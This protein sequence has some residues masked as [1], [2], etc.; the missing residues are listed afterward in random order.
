MTSLPGHLGQPRLTSYWP[1]A[2]LRVRI[3]VG[4]PA[5]SAGAL[6]LR[7]PDDDDLSALAA[8]AEAGVHDPDL[9]P[10]AVPW[11][12]AEPAERARS[13]MQFHWRCLGS[14]S[15]D[16]WTLNLVVVRDGLV[17]GTQGISA[18]DY[19]IVRE[20]DTGSWLGKQHQ[21]KGTG[22]AMRAAVL[23]LAFDGLGAQYARSEA[24]SDNPAS[25][26]VSRKLGY[27]D[28]GLDRMAIRGLPAKSCR[29]R[30]S[31]TTWQAAGG[32]SGLGI[33][34]V[35]ING[36]EPCLSLFGIDEPREADPA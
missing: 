34:D 9:Q 28:D 1:I 15:P 30:I 36:L 13:V 25:L 14:W 35:T 26:A 19:R 5:G 18:R 32:A 21:G 24:F 31:R 7:A 16:D 33:G 23:A 4:A 17:V 29:L 6:E 11:T 8:L 20:V 12:D 3:T 2:G 27:V 10:F 22:T